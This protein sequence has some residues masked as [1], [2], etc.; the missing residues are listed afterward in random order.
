[1]P[2]HLL[3]VESPAKAKTINKYLGKDFTVLASYGH[4]RD[5]V[6]KEGAVDPDNGFAMRY[7]LIEKNE[8]HVDAIAKAAK[9]A[10]DIF[11]ATD[12]DR[13][14]EA[15]SWH[16]AEILKERG[17]LKDKPLHRVVFTEITPRAIK[18][19]MA[20]P[21]QIAGDLVDAQQA[22]RALDYLV[23][24]NLSP[25]LWRK[26]QRGL[27]AGRVQSPALRMIV[28]RE[29]E[30]EAFIAREYWS[31]EAECAHPRQAF[32]AK[33]TKL[34][35][36][37]FEQFT[38]TDGDT[39]EA[40]RLRIQQ[41]A[42]G[43][44]HVTDVTSKE[45]KRRPAPPFTTST[46]QQEA[47]RKLGFTTRKTMQVAQKLYEG[48]NIGDEEGTVGLISYMRTDS[49]SLSAEALA[50]IRDVIARDFGTQ[51]LPDKPNVY[52][53][54][55]KNAQEAHE[56]VRPTSALRTPSQ[57]AKYLSDDERKLYDLIWKR[58]VACQ[59]VP[60]T[61][62]T[63]SVDLAAG[64]AHSFRA[65]GTTVVDPGFLAVYE[66]G[67]DQKNAEDDDEGRKLPPM[68]PGDT[69]PLDRIH[70]DQ[71]FTQPPPRFT[72][73]ALVKALEEYGIG[74]PST[75]ASI[76][77][78]L[79]F[80]KYVEMEGRAFK[81]SDVGRA[82]SKFL[83]GHFTQYVDY[84]F[85]AKLED[86]LDAVSRGEED[87][88][89]LM[90]RFWGPFKDLVAE[91]AETV[92]RSEATG[93]REL[94]TDAKSGKPV[95]VRLGRY[96]PYAQIGDKDTDEKLEFASL[97][98]G[99][100][101]HTITLE[102]A[103]ELFKLPRKLGQ[104]KDEEVS[105]GIGRFGPFAKRGS[106]YASLKKE[107]DPY[108]IDLARAVFLIEEK[109][110]IA[111]NRIIKDFDGSDI[112]VLNGRFGP[113]ISDGKLNG[114]IPKDR[115]PAS[116]TLVEVQKLLEETGKPVRKGF[117]K[118]TAAKKAVVKKEAA[119]K[120]TA[121]KKA[122]AKKTAKKAAKKTATTSASKKT[123]TKKTVKKA[124]SKAVAGDDAPF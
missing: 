101:M 36:Q 11:L 76:I 117:G 40:A 86:E 121:A 58:A 113:Y 81:P 91:K 103:L 41:A 118:K 55:S 105:V 114:K 46:L 29:E 84:D 52:V 59:M 38:V 50:E 100:S 15:I 56:A 1:M 4:V 94:G 93:A 17:L 16:I 35:G 37:K 23:G 67:K 45:R 21:R 44:L 78:T 14:G 120:K 95:S 107:D 53:T 73:A 123:A 3:I 71:H 42:Q 31:I 112:Q 13:E 62:N 18:E 89:P 111:R 97:R 7:D 64:S 115:E 90:E 28:E 10:D 48:V 69:V 34:D 43:M 60:A 96:G 83:S 79:Q 80:R 87:W 68:K 2:K 24:F 72:E 106:V 6:P 57:V 27:S 98:P 63:V 66:E 22:R 116:L 104:D 77:Q 33:L 49:V 8:K 51:A 19:A 85:T 25:V 75:Y 102:D 124:A 108:T 65:S 39:A 99:Q 82:V 47:S 54:K 32:T 26:V 5:L 110:E 119:P 70:A 20:Q 30:I 61:L 74:R 12:P 88:V 92:D 9:G 122:P 109:E